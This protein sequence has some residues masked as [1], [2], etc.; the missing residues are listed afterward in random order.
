[1]KRFVVL[2]MLV[3]WATGCATGPGPKEVMGKYLDAYG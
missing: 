3:M 2:T 1:M